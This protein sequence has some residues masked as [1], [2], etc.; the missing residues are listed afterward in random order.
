MRGGKRNVPETIMVVSVSC[1][2]HMVVLHCKEMFFC[3]KNIAVII[4]EL[5]HRNERG[6]FETREDR[7]CACCTRK[8]VG[9]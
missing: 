7:G 5:A 4:T 9:K 3:E 8:L 1:E 2:D 6:S